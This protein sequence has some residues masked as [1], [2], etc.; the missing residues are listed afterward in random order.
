MKFLVNFQTRNFSSPVYPGIDIS[1]SILSWSVLGGPDEAVLRATGRVQRLLESVNLLR[2]SIEISDSSGV[3]VWWGYVNSIDIF[4]DGIK[5]SVSLDFLFNR[6]KV[7]YSFISPDNKLADQLETANANNTASQLEYGIRHIILHESNIDENFA[8]GLR[9]TYLE[10][11]SWP[12]SILSEKLNNDSYFAEYHCLGWFSTLDWLP[13]E[14]SDGFFANYGPGPGAFN[15][16]FATARFPA[17]K[18][19]PGAA[20]NV[21]YAY[22][23]LRKNLAPTGNLVARIYSDAGGSPNAILATSAAVVASTLPSTS[24]A[25]TRF[26]F[27]TA[28]GLS[29]TTPY[30]IA[31]A[32]TVSDAVNNC[33]IK[34]D[35]DAGYYQSGHS[36]KYWDGAAW[37]SVPNITSPGT[38]PDLMFRVVAISDTGTQLTSITSVGNQFF[39]R[40]VSLTTNMNISPYRIEQ[41]S[42]LDYIKDIM[43]LGTSNHRL[44]LSSVSPERYLSYYEQPSKDP[45]CFMDRNGRF[46]TLFGLPL[47]PWNPP[48]G[49]YAYLSS[50]NFHTLPFDYSRIPTC[51]VYSAKYNCLTQRLSINS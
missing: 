39:P 45:T 50:T 18:F 29:S 4:L 5:I 23:R 46:F 33:Y 38:N 48:V 20:C 41:K 22:F 11:H 34:I 10:Q 7:V 35:E 24:Y 6:V 36:A 47:S 27:S 25:W 26:T 43:Q 15:F 2:C 37:V 16:G 28:Y 17:Q 9:D 42:C 13:Y 32:R 8:D 51:F 49:Q 21:K 44:I 14:N 1:P 40:A 31:C 3:P 12:T 30:W 19:T